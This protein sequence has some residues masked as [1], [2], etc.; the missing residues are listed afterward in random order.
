LPPAST[1]FVEQISK[2][3][4]SSDGT[5]CETNWTCGT[6]HGVL[7]FGFVVIQA[8]ILQL[9]RAKFFC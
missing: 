2:Q 9:L 8:L 5:P 1:I 3:E 6:K 7:S 4:T